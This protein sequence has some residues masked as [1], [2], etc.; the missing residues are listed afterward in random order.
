MQYVPGGRRCHVGRLA[1][2]PP[3]GKPKPCRGYLSDG[4]SD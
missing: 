1:V 2:R 4:H 3:A